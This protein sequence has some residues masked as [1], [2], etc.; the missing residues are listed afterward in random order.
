MDDFLPP[1]KTLRDYY[2]F[3]GLW[4]VVWLLVLGEAIRRRDLSPGRKRF[5]LAVIILVPVVGALLYWVLASRYHPGAP[6]NPG[7]SDA[8]TDATHCVT[9]QTPM[10]PGTTSCPKCGWSYTGGED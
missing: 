1:D 9:C 5:W 4:L 2:L 8:T 6:S 3:L 10:P 7:E